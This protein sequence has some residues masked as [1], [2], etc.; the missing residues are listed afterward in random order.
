MLMIYE[1]EAEW[2]ALDPETANKIMSHHDAFKRNNRSRL[3]GG[4]P[5]MPTATA[6]T[7]RANDGGGF[8]ITDAPFAETKEALGGYYIIEAAHIDEALEIAKQ[9]PAPFGCVE[10]RPV[11]ELG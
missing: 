10:V 9:V 7:V 5:L 4:H 8:L 6:T 2:A 1:N 11:R 3:R